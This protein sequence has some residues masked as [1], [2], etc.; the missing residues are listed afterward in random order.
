MDTSQPR[1]RRLQQLCAVLRGEKRSLLGPASGRRQFCGADGVPVITGIKS[2]KTAPY[3]TRLVVVK[4]TTSTPGLTGVGCATF[5]QR[6]TLVCAAV[7]EYLRPFLLGRRVSE[8]EDIW[9]AAFV[10]SYWRSGPVLNNALS[11][12][13]QAL[14]DIKGKLAGMP[15]HDLLGGK[16]RKAAPVYVHASGNTF[17]EVCTEAKKYMDLGFRTIRMQCA[18]K[19]S[20]GGADY[21]AS[22]AYSNKLEDK[23]TE[24]ASRIAEA[25]A[26]TDSVA[27]DG[28]TDQDAMFVPDDYLLQT[29]ALFKYAREQLGEEVELCHDTHERLTP[30][31]S[32]HLAKALEPY[33]LF[34]LEDSLPPEQNEHFKLI[35]EAG[36]LCW[37]SLAVVDWGRGAVWCVQASTQRCPSRWVSCSLTCMSTCLSS[38]IGSST[39]SECICPTSV[40]RCTQWQSCALE[41]G[42]LTR[43]AC[44]SGCVGA[45]LTPMRKLATLCEFFG[46]RTAL[47]GPGDCSPVGMMANLAIDL[48]VSNFGIQE[49]ADIS[50]VTS[51][52]QAP[53]AA[54]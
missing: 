11:G 21:G 51:C 40:V 22:K 38:K 48:S 41:F 37:L 53:G 24:S 49:Y 17:D 47:H 29:P 6:P 31:Q 43:V 35:R 36:P 14:W 33:R 46:V 32:V 2:I 19:S 5:T 3:G 20:F 15:V 52:R 42:G 12:V 7:D 30:S 50:R 27:S 4:V 16:T 34:F 45:G 13:D 26:R 23:V 18:T 54:A 1:N 39:T 28:P 25:A 9:Q 8:I 10:S 44:C